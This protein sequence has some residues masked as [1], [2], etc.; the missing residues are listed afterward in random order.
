MVV[1]VIHNRYTADYGV[2]STYLGELFDADTFEIIVSRTSTDPDPTP[3]LTIK[4]PEDEG[5]EKWK[6]QVP[7]KLCHVSQ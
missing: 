6:I 4:I 3:Q 2:L 1:Q 5:G 7:R